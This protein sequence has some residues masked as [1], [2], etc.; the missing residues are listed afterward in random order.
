MEKLSKVVTRLQMTENE[1]KSGLELGTW[2][3]KPNDFE[4]APRTFVVRFSDLDW[5]A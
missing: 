2:R 5:F 3:F 1:K 4:F